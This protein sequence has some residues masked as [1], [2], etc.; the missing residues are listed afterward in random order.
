MTH[1]FHVQVQDLPT[2]CFRSTRGRLR[3]MVVVCWLA[4]SPQRTPGQ[5]H[6]GTEEAAM[7]LTFPYRLVPILSSS[8]VQ[9]CTAACEY[10]VR[11]Q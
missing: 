7:T 5:L 9:S 8:Y 10:R 1:V 11:Q 6:K 4:Q 2:V 3:N